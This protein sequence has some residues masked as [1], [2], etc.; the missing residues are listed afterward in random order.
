MIAEA[1]LLPKTIKN[2]FPFPLLKNKFPI[3][4]NSN[5]MIPAIKLITEQI[6]KINKRSVDIEEIT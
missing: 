4:L 6:G 1:M 3:S 5:V 2:N